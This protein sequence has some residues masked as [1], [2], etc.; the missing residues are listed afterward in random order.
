MDPGLPK[1]V[2]PIQDVED[3][4][5][6]MKSAYPDAIEEIPPNA[7]IPRG[8]SIRMSCFV[9]ANHASDKITRRSQSGII[10]YCNSAPILWYSKRQNTVELSTF[11]GELVAFRLA[12]ELV[13]SLR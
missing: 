5:R 1:I 11:G 10:I 8:K 12:T 6:N 2:K 7:P 9:D 3:R 13:M 4:M